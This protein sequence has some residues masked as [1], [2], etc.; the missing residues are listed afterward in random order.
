MYVNSTKN[1]NPAFYFLET[2]V[3]ISKVAIL[4]YD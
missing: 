2:I 3:K 1:A 4:P